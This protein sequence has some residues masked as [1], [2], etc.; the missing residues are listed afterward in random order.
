MSLRYGVEQIP[1]LY[2]GYHWA[3]IDRNE[4]FRRTHYAGVR[5][6]LNSVSLHHTE[7][8]AQEMADNLNA[9]VEL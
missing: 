6:A 9:L 1:A 4:A 7:E 2:G 5:T 3:V 8:A